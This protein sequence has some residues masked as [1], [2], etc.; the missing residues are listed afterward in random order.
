M[1][2]SSNPSSAVIA[3]ACENGTARLWDSQSGQP[4]GE[5]LEHG[6]P[7][8]CL[9]F[10]PGEPYWPAAAATGP[11]GSGTRRPAWRSVRPW[12]TGASGP[13]AFLQPRWAAACHRFGKRPGPILEGRA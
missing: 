12:S 3:V 4:F 10:G 2:V 5:P 7:I 1:I 11:S 6:V 9:E 8:E 13:F